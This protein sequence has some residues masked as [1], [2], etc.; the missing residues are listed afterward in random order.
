MDDSSDF[1]TFTTARL[2]GNW[3]SGNGLTIR[4]ALASGFL[5]PSVYQ[6]FGDTSQYINIAPNSTINP[7]TSFSAELGAVV[8]LGGGAM[9]GAT[10][11][12]L[13]I[14]NAINFCGLD[15]TRCTS[16]VF[17]LPFTNA[18]ENVAGTSH[19]RGVEMEFSAPVAGDWTLNGNYTY[20]DA[21]LPS[22]M[23][24]SSVPRN[25]LSLGLAGDLSDRLSADVAV[26]GVSGLL[27]GTTELP[28]FVKADATLT[29]AVNDQTDAY[30]RVENIGDAT[31]QT[32]AG[33]GTSGRALYVGIRAKF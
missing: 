24:F 3:R 22:G 1:G 26:V 33:Y 11:F 25:K 19:R 21:T 8:E 14:D 16:A 28:S 29:Y 5:A 10:V 17:A 6:R 18:Y 13:D 31:F 7:E 20:T 15:A 32:K 27:D 30:L 12:A 23:R 9:I 2:A 4:G